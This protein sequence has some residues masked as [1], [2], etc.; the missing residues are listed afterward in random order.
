LLLGAIGFGFEADD[1]YLLT[2]FTDASHRAKDWTLRIILWTI[3][4]KGARM[5][6]CGGGARGGYV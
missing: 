4:I 6:R 3:R 5:R 2:D 1:G